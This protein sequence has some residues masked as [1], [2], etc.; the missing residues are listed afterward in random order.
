MKDN[1]RH[2]PGSTRSCRPPFVF[3]RVDSWSTKNTYKTQ[4]KCRH[5]FKGDFL[6]NSPS[7]TY[8]FNALTCL[9][10]AD[11]NLDLTP[12]FNLNQPCAPRLGPAHHPFSP[13]AKVRMRDKLVNAFANDPAD[14]NFPSLYRMRQNETNYKWSENQ[15]RCTNEL[16]RHPLH[17]SHFV[18]IWRAELRDAMVRRAIR[19]F[20]DDFRLF[21]QRT[22]LHQQLATTP[23]AIVR[24]GSRTSLELGVGTARR[25]RPLM[26]ALQSRRIKMTHFGRKNGWGGASFFETGA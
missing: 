23:R 12:N 14:K 15:P 24:I 16:R 19:T 21:R 5:N 4:T 9:N 25:R 1:A 3:I 18:R 26:P 13:G 2:V 20:P 6:S 17:A 7:I 22:T 10:S 11:P 8:N